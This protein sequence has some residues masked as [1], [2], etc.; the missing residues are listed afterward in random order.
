M[1]QYGLTAAAQRDL[2]DIVDYLA[3]EN[4]EA[5]RRLVDQLLEAFQRLAEMPGMGRSQ[6]RR[7]PNLRSWTVGSYL[8]FYRPA[9]EGVEIIR[10]V[11]GRRD[12]DRLI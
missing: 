3:V 10:V 1:S 5:A 2:G 11:H 8:V 9:A 4:P 12:L 6:E 7:Q